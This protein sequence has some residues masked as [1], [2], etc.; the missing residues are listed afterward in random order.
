M[1]IATL[2]GTDRMARDELLTFARDLEAAGIESLWL[3]EVLGRDPF[4]VA[5]YLL[6]H[7][8]LIHI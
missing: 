4:T 6:S 5:G 7:L 3:P 1:P 8:S 2:Y